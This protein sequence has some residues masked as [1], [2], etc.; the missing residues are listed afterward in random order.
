MAEEGAGAGSDDSYY[1]DV[2]DDCVV[3]AA[4]EVFEKLKV[5]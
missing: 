5:L 1:K 4:V 3:K 2:G